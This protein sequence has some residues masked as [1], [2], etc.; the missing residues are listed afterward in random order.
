[1]WLGAGL[2]TSAIAILIYGYTVVHGTD[3][4]LDQ[5]DGL[6]VGNLGLGVAVIGAALFLYG[7]VTEFLRFW[8]VRLGHHLENRPRSE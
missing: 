6:A 5:R 7:A 8:M 2:M 1:M 4:A 3:N